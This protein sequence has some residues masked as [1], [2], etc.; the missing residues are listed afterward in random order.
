[1]RHICPSCLLRCVMHGMTLRMARPCLRR[2]LMPYMFFR[3]C[4]VYM[5]KYTLSF[6][7][8]CINIHRNSVIPALFRARARTDA[9]KLVSGTLRIALS[10]SR[11]CFIASPDARSGVTEEP[12]SGASNGSSVLQKSLFR[13]T[14]MRM[15]RSDCDIPASQNVFFHVMTVVFPYSV[16]CFAVFH[17][18]NFLLLR[19]INMQYRMLLCEPCQ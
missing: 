10:V 7:S 16:F 18:Q 13:M 12:P 9:N 4:I 8:L 19:C 5:Y 6:V 17:C 11:L 2:V 15:L 1:M 14:V 3:Q